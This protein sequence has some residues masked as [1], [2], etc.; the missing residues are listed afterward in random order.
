MD[1]LG[2]GAGGMWMSADSSYPPTVWRFE[3]LTEISR[4][5]VSDRN[6]TGSI[7]NSEL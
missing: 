5:V 6:P 2:I 1:A 7:T 3:W 4:Q